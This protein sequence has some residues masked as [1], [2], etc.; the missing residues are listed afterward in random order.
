MDLTEA[1]SP[2]QTYREAVKAPYYFQVIGF[3]SIARE[4]S[5]MHYLSIRYSSCYAGISPAF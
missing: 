2:L 5:K 3:F 1:C 4:T